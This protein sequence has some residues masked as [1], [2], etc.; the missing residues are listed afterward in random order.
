LDLFSEVSV[1][2]DEV[3]PVAGGEGKGVTEVF[4][5][6]ADGARQGRMLYE[7]PS[8]VGKRLDFLIHHQDVGF[9]EGFQGDAGGRKGR[10]EGEVED[11]K[12]ALVASDEGVVLEE[13]LEGWAR[14]AG[15][16]RGAARRSSHHQE[17]DLQSV[18][19]HDGHHEALQDPAPADKHPGFVLER[20]GGTA[21]AGSLRPRCF[22]KR[23]L[24]KQHPVLGSIWRRSIGLYQHPQDD[25]YSCSAVYRARESKP[26][27]IAPFV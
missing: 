14:V 6:E 16:G 22:F 2:G 7:E 20:F 21:S 3:F 13:V 17:K 18:E 19:K 4:G 12:E 8:E 1:G 15:G 26:H 11:A 10:E 25:Q 5:M 27:G 24:H 9:E 23:Q